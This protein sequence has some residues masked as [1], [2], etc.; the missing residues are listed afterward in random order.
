MSTDAA[1]PRIYRGERR[2]WRPHSWRGGSSPDRLGEIMVWD[3]AT[4]FPQHHLDFGGLLESN[5]TIAAREWT[6]F[7]A[8]ARSRGPARSDG[9][10]EIPPQVLRVLGVESMIL[11]DWGHRGSNSMKPI[12][13]DAV[14]VELSPPLPRAWIVHEVAWLPHQTGATWQ[15]LEARTREVWFPERDRDWSHLAVVESD[16][17]EDRLREPVLAGESCRLV[18]YTPQQVRLA[19]SLRTTGQIVLSD[20]YDAGWQAHARKAGDTAWLPLRTVRTNRILRSVRLGPGDWELVWTYRPWPFLLG[21][22]ISLTAW[23]WLAWWS[24]R[25]GLLIRRME[26]RTGL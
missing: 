26:R 17:E 10:R 12:A 3:T 24:L 25:R 5:V 14:R 7:C 22:G 9:R 4:R 19:V 1:P 2:G 13:E 21:L 15:E 8:V 20:R 11:P 16:R 23:A 18:E 6:A